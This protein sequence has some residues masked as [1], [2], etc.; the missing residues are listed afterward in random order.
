MYVLFWSRIFFNAFQ[1]ITVDGNV[2][3]A[4]FDGLIPQTSY[5][6]E[7]AGVK[8]EKSGEKGDT[9]VL[10]RTVSW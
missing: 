4:S 5:I 9:E 1:S 2:N 7:V 8:K 10:T 6:V 3:N